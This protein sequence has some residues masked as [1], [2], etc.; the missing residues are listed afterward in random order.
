MEGFQ[1]ASIYFTYNKQTAFRKL[2][3]P[4]AMMLIL[5]IS[6]FTCPPSGL[7]DVLRIT[8]FSALS[9]YALFLMISFA[10]YRSTRKDSGIYTISVF[11]SVSL[12]VQGVYMLDSEVATEMSVLATGSG[13]A[14]IFYYVMINR[15]RESS[16][17]ISKDGALS[18]LIRGEEVFGAEFT[19]IRS[20]WNKGGDL[21][22]ELTDSAV[23]PIPS[24]EFDNTEE[25]MDHI[26]DQLSVVSS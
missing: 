24:S 9:M 4:A 5:V 7:E 18:I 21:E 25:V 3:V 23:I 13:A 12:M 2:M 15:T 6:L 8:A 14:G 26:K 22:L 16:L 20:V 17:M 1:P 10:R 11:L 19:D